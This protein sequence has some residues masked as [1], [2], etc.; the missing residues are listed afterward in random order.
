MASITSAAQAA[1]AAADTSPGESKENTLR[2][3]TQALVQNMDGQTGPFWKAALYAVYFYNIHLQSSYLTEEE[4]DDTYFWLPLDLFEWRW[5][6]K[7]QELF[8]WWS[9]THNTNGHYII[10]PAEFVPPEETWMQC[11]ATLRQP[12][13]N[14]MYNLPDNSEKITYWDVFMQFSKTSTTD[15]VTHCCGEYDVH[16][17]VRQF[18][19]DRGCPTDLEKFIRIWGEEDR[20]LHRNWQKWAQRG[21]EEH[22]VELTV[23]VTGI[24]MKE[25]RKKN[26]PPKLMRQATWFGKF[27]PHS[28]ACPPRERVEQ[29]GD[30]TLIMTEVKAP[31][32]LREWCSLELVSSFRQYMWVQKDL[33]AGLEWMIDVIWANLTPEERDDIRHMLEYW[34]LTDFRVSIDNWLHIQLLHN[35]GDCFTEQSKKKI[36][37]MLIPRT[38]KW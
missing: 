33:P 4:V 37:W 16:P 1:I 9:F 7:I 13:F 38:A 11:E 25:C 5:K 26:P 21:F 23:K 34:R 36:D 32:S 27:Y 8:P 24:T 6:K 28:N 17:E 2:N 10:E 31:E 29:E 3:K 35:F 19:V 18:I 30:D 20:E 22:I 15:E 14:T 12:T